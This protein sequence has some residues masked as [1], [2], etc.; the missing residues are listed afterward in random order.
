MGVRHELRLLPAADSR[1][2][3]EPPLAEVTNKG[4]IESEST[5]FG[6]LPTKKIFLA[7]DIR[8]RPSAAVSRL[9]PSS[10][11][12]VTPRSFGF[13]QASVSVV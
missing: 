9:W 3:V 11:T 1:V 8:R 6:V 7:D 13:G 4:G 5:K 2:D 10:S 12:L